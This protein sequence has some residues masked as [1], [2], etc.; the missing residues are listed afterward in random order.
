MPFG[1]RF[2]DQAGNVILG[3]A[4]FLGALL[5]VALEPVK[6]SNGEVPLHRLVRDLVSRRAFGRRFLGDA[7]EKLGFYRDV[8]GAHG[9]PSV[10]FSP[11]S[12]RKRPEVGKP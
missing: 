2:S 4:Q 8:L 6:P 11:S 3:D 7:G 5:P 9:F 10:N 1:S 12:S